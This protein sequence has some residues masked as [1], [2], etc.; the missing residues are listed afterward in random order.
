M[1]KQF[2]SMKNIEAGFSVVAQSDHFGIKIFNL[3]RVDGLITA[4]ASLLGQA[5][6]QEYRKRLET[7]LENM[8]GE[9]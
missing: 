2:E 7:T 1:N 9:K 4:Y 8:K 5:K 6:V 3:G